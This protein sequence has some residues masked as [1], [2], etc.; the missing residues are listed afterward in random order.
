MVNSF[1][2]NQ[3]PSSLN[4][5]FYPNA[6]TGKKQLTAVGDATNYGC[7]DENKDVPDDD[8]TYVYSTNTS[9]V[10]DIYMLPNHTTEA[11]IINYV[12]VFARAKSNLYNQAATGIYKLLVSTSAVTYSSV[13]IDLT[14]DY[15]TYNKL[16]IQ[17]P[18][19]SA[20]WT[21]A[22]IDDLKIGI[23][24]SSPSI[25]GFAASQ[26]LRPNG[27]GTN[28]VIPS[29]WPAS[30]DHFDKVDDVIAD[31]ADTYVINDTNGGNTW[32]TDTYQMENLT[33]SGTITDVTILHRSKSWKN[34]NYYNS[35]K[36]VV[37]LNPSY[38]YGDDYFSYWVYGTHSDTFTTKPGGGAW[39]FADVNN[40]EIGVS[41]HAVYESGYTSCTQIYAIVHYIADINPEIRTTQCYAMVNYTPS[42]TTCYLNMPTDY[43]FGSNYE[44]QKYNWWNTTRTTRAL[45]RTSK[46]VSLSGMEYMSQ[47]S[48]PTARLKCVENMKDNGSP[49][50]LSGLADSN[51]NSTWIIREFKYD[52]SQDNSNVWK[53]DMTLEKYK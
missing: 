10:T 18:A 8:A 16:W 37:Y 28:T 1:T 33:G 6:D 40:M 43:S 22:N 12:Q 50:T 48:T 2:I 49:I 36:C 7:V 45:R 34:D 38:L 21:W 11:G 24:C 31:D 19:T 20:A 30:G 53:W 41:L 29:Q 23:A 51:L 52:V 44:I 13:D 26:T 15:T 39:T 32:K 46:T 35:S 3:T 47:T 5:F 4:S 9:I 17:N 14:T 42:T 27:V 25:I